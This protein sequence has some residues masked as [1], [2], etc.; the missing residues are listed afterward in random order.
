MLAWKPIRSVL[1]I[2]GLALGSLVL[3]FPEPLFETARS[4]V[5]A[6]ALV[7]LLLSMV[8]SRRLTLN[9]IIGWFGVTS[10][11]GWMRASD[12]PEAFSH[13]TGVALGLFIMSV[14][15]SWC[16]TEAR[17]RLATALSLLAGVGVLTVGALGVGAYQE[18]GID[19]DIMAT[20]PQVTLPLPGLVLRSGVNRN[21]LGATVLL[22]APLGLALAYRPR[23]SNTW[24]QGLRLLGGLLAVYGGLILMMTQS[25]SALIAA[26]SMSALLF[27]RARRRLRM[28]L[29]LPAVLVTLS[30]LLVT[31]LYRLDGSGRV[32]AL[33]QSSVER[34]LEVWHQGVE[35]LKDSPWLGIGL[36]RFREVYRPAG[37][38]SQALDIA[39]AHNIFLQTALDVGLIGLAAYVG[40]LTIVL[41]RAD[42][43][44]RGTSR[45]AA[46]VA[47]GAGLSVAGVHLFGLG[48]AVSLGAKVGLFQWVAAGLVLGAWEIQRRS[49]AVPAAAK[50][51]VSVKTARDGLGGPRPTREPS[52][53]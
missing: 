7:A 6:M 44:A 10:Y 38:M 29:I 25:R 52:P 40:L 30:A 4:W 49:G 11:Y 16:R 22:L 50:A 1:T 15:G 35:H 42:R 17:L 23:Q 39:H 43:A 24:G 41:I 31:S 36:N 2:L 5:I 28:R 14:L 21:A 27:F 19:L 3:V 48:D 18:K 20:L 33:A 26:F 9:W 46:H 12:S 13:F 53:P 51:A 45:L 32:L 34:R 37:P 47:A 8:L